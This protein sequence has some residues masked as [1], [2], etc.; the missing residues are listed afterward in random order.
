MNPWLMTLVMVFAWGILA[1]QLI[2]KFG[3][4]TK[5]APESRFK[6]IRRRIGRL[7]KM[8]IGQERLIG[9]SRE[10]GSGIMHAFIFWGALVIGVRELTLMGE[11]FATGFQEY[12]PFLGSDSI[13]GFIYI[14]VYNVAE[15]V[16][17]ALVLVALYR[18]IWPKP[19]RLELNWE[20]IYVLLFIVAIMLTDIL[21]DAARYNLV[22]NFGHNLHFFQSAEYGTEWQW[23]PAVSYTHLTLPTKA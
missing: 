10:R 6:D 13:L 5:M 2:V 14:S 21:F 20:G 16:V 18:R 23:A 17:L 12:L 3:A 19:E 8:G 1:L 9:R 15:V 4:L 11:G 7:I 22:E